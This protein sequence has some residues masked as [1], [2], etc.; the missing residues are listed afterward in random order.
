MWIESMNSFET[1]CITE[2]LRIDKAGLS[3]TIQSDMDTTNAFSVKPGMTLASQLASH[4]SCG[5]FWMKWGWL[6]IW[7]KGVR[8]DTE[9]DLAKQRNQK[10]LNVEPQSVVE[11]IAYRGLG[12]GD[13]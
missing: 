10:Q 12:V 2:G 6:G 11:T 3:T 5:L 7:G 4:T 9:N 13:H 8:P 1:Q